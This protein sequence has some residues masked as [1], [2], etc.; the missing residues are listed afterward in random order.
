P[1]RLRETI[2]ALIDAAPP[3]I[4]LG[5]SASYGLDLVARGLDWKPGDEVLYVDGA[6]PASVFPWHAAADQGVQIRSFRAAQGDVPCPDELCHHILPQT[7][8]FVCSWVNS[9]TGHTLDVARTARVCPGSWRGI[10]SQ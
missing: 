5:N 4:I 6:F 8:V 7:R 10:R 3:D 9:F 2:G 1:Q